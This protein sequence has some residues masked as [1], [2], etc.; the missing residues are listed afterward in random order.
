MARGHALDALTIL[1]LTESVNTATKIS[2]PIGDAFTQI[3]DEVVMG[4]DHLASHREDLL[5]RALSQ[6]D[7]PLGDFSFHGPADALR[8][9]RNSQHGASESVH[10]S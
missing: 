3:V 5:N 1:L 2:P 8:R 6:S 7:A 4:K 9:D 10:E